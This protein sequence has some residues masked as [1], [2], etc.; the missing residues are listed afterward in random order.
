M[1]LVSKNRSHIFFEFSSFRLFSSQNVRILA[2]TCGE[3]AQLFC[4]PTGDFIYHS[5]FEEEKLRIDLTYNKQNNL[6]H[7]AW[8]EHRIQRSFDPFQFMIT[9]DH[10]IVWRGPVATYPALVPKKHL[11]ATQLTIRRKHIFQ[12]RVQEKWLLTKP[13][14]MALTAAHHML[15]M[16]VY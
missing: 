12:G 1:N 7:L 4:F 16:S 6:K 13:N 11:R 15:G 9:E 3:R 2:V 10:G 14:A 8:K 5:V